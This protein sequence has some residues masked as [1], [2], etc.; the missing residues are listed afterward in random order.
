M[1]GEVRSVAWVTKYIRDRVQLDPAL[2]RIAIRGEVSNFNVQARGHLNF[3]LTEGRDVLLCFAWQDDFLT[4]PAFKN[5]AKVIATGRVTTYADRS[6]YQLIVDAVRIEGVGDAHAIFEER[7]RRLAAEGL[8]DP[9]R[10]RPLPPYPFRVALVSSKRADGAI[11]FVT[12][13]RALRPHVR[14]VL[15]ETSVQGPNAPTEIVGALARA[16]QLDVDCIVLTRGG[17]SFED[18]FAFSDENVVGGVAR[19]TQPVRSAVGHTVDQQL[20]DFVADL[21]AETPSAAAERIG[22]ETEM[23]AETVARYARQIRR[24]INEGLGGRAGRLERALTRSK[25]GDARLFLLPLTQRLGDAEVRRERGWTRNLQRVRERLQRA[26]D[27]LARFDPGVRL[28]RRR[29][30]LRLTGANLDQA[31]RFARLRFEQRLAGAALRL[32]GNDPEAILKKGYAIVTHAGRIVRDPS[33]VPVGEL[34]RA[35]LARGT[36]AARVEADE[37]NGNERIG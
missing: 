16:S 17:G 11:D 21:H 35:R 23:L 15:C 37:S 30:T 25:L 12:R 14:V 19:A 18:L 32:H 3:A 7:K 5:G 26:S 36:L 27:K 22:P 6:I 13:L 24:A 1:N 34:V 2:R 29:E 9:A 8:F 4:F 28:A 20:C 31:L 10:K 33:Q